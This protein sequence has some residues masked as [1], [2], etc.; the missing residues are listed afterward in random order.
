MKKRIQK[1]P[2]KPSFSAAI[3]IK[4]L[5]GKKYDK[6]KKNIYVNE[7]KFLNIYSNFFRIFLLFK[8]IMYYNYVKRYEQK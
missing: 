7:R 6:E 1:D 8:Y 2:C 3:S 4:Y 5:H